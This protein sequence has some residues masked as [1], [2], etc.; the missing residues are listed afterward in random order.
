MKSHKIRNDFQN[1]TITIQNHKNEDKN[2]LQ[3]LR[4]G[5]CKTGLSPP[6]TLCY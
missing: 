4:L 1:K 6:V 2:P 5:S 3:K